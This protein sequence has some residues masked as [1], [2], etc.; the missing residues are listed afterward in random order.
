M[1][2]GNADLWERYWTAFDHKNSKVAVRKVKAHCGSSEVSRGIIS[3]KDLAGNAFAD[4]LADKGAEEASLP[5]SVLAEF[6]AL[7]ALAWCIQSR[8]SAIVC[9]APTKQADLKEAALHRQLKKD[10]ASRAQELGI[11]GNADVEPEP[12]DEYPGGDHGDGQL[13]NAENAVFP[14]KRVGGDRSGLVHC[15]HRRRVTRGIMWC[16]RCGAYGQTRGRK[17]TRECKGVPTKSANFVLRRLA[18]GLTP[19]HSVDWPEDES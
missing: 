16:V 13:L 14:E 18:K 10:T 4:V 7:D 12:G 17:L 2:S 9:A 5:H 1:Y 3:P 8:I 6:D 15:S 11:P 19:H